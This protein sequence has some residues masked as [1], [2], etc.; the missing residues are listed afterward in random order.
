M[1]LTKEDI[2]HI[3]RIK[4]LNIIN[5]ITGIKPANLIGTISNKGETNLAIFSS[6][7][8][9]GSNPALLGFVV[10]PST[11]ER[12]HT[13]ENIR[14]NGFYTINHVHEQFV[15]RAHFT[16]AKFEKEESEFE[17]CALTEEYLTGFKAPFVKESQFK[18]G[19]RFVQSVPIEINGTL[20]MIGEIEHLVLP[21]DALNKEGYIDL[22]KSK[23]IG[24]SG[25]N[26][27]YEVKLLDEFPFARPEEL[28]DFSR[29]K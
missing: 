18:M 15:E 8:H 14:E 22:S 7:V 4:R 25:L 13:L 20:L 1:H 26:R 10:R 17:K 3:E 24:I 12:R 6:V 11:E 21:D 9:L 16:S 2:K 27:Y 23:S 28:P 5:A 19:M 29:F